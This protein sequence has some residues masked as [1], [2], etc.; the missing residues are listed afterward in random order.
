M[1][2]KNQ[3]KNKAHNAK[4]RKERNAK[5]GK[6]KKRSKANKPLSEAEMDNMIAAI[7]RGL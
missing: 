7:E 5:R 4:L 3:K 1:A 2:Y 6:S